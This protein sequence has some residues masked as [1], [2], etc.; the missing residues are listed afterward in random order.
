MLQTS[1]N[2]SASSVPDNSSPL[3]RSKPRA[4]P[5]PFSVRLSESERARLILEAAGIPLGTYIKVKALGAPLPAR[6][7]GLGIE[8]RTSL[9]KV[10]A[11]LGTSHLASNLNQLAKAVNSGSLP[12]TP[13]TEA[14][15]LAT[16]Q[17]VREMRALLM[18]ALGLK[19][20]VL[21]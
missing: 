18:R 16:M 9:A 15:L 21:A 13:E 10:L 7:S 19:V 14:E 6:R 8:D 12:L 2:R 17:A 11:L 5:S 3:A 20:E 1:F 4:K